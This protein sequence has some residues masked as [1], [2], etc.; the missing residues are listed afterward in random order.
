MTGIYAGIVIQ[1]LGN[2]RKFGFPTANLRLPEGADIAK[3][4]YAVWVYVEGKR[5]EGMLYVGSRPTLFLNELTYEI[6][7]FN[8]TGDLYGRELAFTIVKHLRE[9]EHF[10]GIEALE[11]QL[12]RDREAARAALEQSPHPIPDC[13]RQTDNHH[14]I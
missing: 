13:S 10:S 7:I 1:G 4:V 9:E 8:F 2:G 12:L 11:A 14:E 5:Y 3:G 6:N